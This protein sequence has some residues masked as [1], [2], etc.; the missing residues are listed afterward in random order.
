MLMARL[1]PPIATLLVLNAAAASAQDGRTVVQAAAANMGAT[2][3]ASIQYFG[4]GWIA[5]AGQ[6]F[7]LADDWPRWEVSG[8]SRII[9]YGAHASREE[10]VRRQEATRLAVAAGRRSRVSSAS[11]R[12]SV[13]HTRGT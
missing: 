13:R 9:D 3:L 8:Y 1:L 7:S 5:A 11:Q 4:S 12:S 2:S 6:S 10:Y